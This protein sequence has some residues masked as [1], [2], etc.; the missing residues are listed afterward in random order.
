[1]SGWSITITTDGCPT[2][3]PTP[4]ASPTPSPSP[5][6]SPGQCSQNFDQVV[7]PALPT[8]WSSVTTT[9]SLPPWVTTTNNPDTP[10]NAAFAGSV[11]SVSNTELISPPFIV[12][13][14]GSQLTFRNAYNLEAGT[15]STGFD[16][17]VLEISINGGPFVDIITAGGSWVTGGYNRTIAS[18]FGS[19][20]A[21]RNAW[22]GLSGGTNTAPAYITTTV[23]L[24]ASA[25]GQLVRMK[26][27]VATDSTAVATGTPGGWV[28]TISGIACTPTA[29]G[30]E[31]S[32][33]VLTPD[34]RGLRNATVTMTDANGVVRT[35]TTSTFGY[36]RFDNVAVGETYVMGVSSRNYRFTPRVVQ[37]VDNMTDVDFIGLE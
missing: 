20:I 28:D 30:V 31:V 6:P 26:W 9:G 8:G 12:S 10:L 35:T 32:G 18:G 36:Y 22:S 4:S 14:G 15:G 7:A 34:G 5:S 23:N 24:P 33:R 16:G 21:G 25:N 17:M 27:R 11:P 1:M 3:T 19:P 13:T 2:P 29:A 37:V